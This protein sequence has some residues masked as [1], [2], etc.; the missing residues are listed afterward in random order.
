[1]EEILTYSYN[2]PSALHKTNGK[3]ELRL[4][5]YSEIQKASDAPC[6][7]RRGQATFYDGALFNCTFQCGEVEF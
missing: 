4:A 3:D 2:I 5:K 1:M 6:F 7:Y